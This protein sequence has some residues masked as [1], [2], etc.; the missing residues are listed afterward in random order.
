MTSFMSV[1]TARSSH[2]S[3]PVRALLLSLSLCLTA[4]LTGP[5]TSHAGSQPY[6]SGH[7]INFATGNKYL[8]ETDLSLGGLLQRFLRKVGR[9]LL[10]FAYHSLGGRMVRSSSGSHLLSLWL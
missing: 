3:R 5:I 2:P 7:G 10:W 8:V 4:L 6:V 9:F 1:K